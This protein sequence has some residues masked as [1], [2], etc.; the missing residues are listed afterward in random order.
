MSSQMCQLRGGGDQR[1]V[2]PKE[3]QVHGS[4]VQ[5][6]APPILPTGS[7]VVP[8]AASSSDLVMAAQSCFWTATVLMW[9][10][11]LLPQDT[12][13]AGIA[14]VTTNTTKRRAADESQRLLRSA[15][16]YGVH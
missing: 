11:T 4:S 2:L 1:T 16:G 15:P 8:R 5:P 13:N 6:P 10:A 3:I 12:G 14:T 7:D 9:P